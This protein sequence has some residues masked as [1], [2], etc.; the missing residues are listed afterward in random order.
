MRFRGHGWCKTFLAANARESTRIGKMQ[1]GCNVAALLVQ[2]LF[3]AFTVI[4]S[5]YFLSFLSFLSWFLREWLAEAW[6]VV[7]ESA[8]AW[9]LPDLP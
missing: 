1:Q 2:N 9:A 6:A 4:F 7:L 8:W 3:V 5:G